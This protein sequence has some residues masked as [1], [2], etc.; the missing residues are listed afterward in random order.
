[1][2]PFDALPGAALVIIRLHGHIEGY[3]FAI[4]PVYRV[5]VPFKFLT[6]TPY[7]GV[8]IE[9]PPYSS[10]RRRSLVYSIR[11]DGGRRARTSVV[12]LVRFLARHY[13]GDRIETEC[14]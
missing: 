2:S 11:G 1:M 13:S 10:E 3:D 14:G 4:Y 5:V 6:S 8:E 12:T 9:L 7:C